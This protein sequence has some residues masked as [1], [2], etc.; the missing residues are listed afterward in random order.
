LIGNGAGG[1]VASEADGLQAQV[2]AGPSAWSAELAIDAALLGGWNHLAGLAFGHHA[3]NAGGDDYAW[4]YAATWT[5]PDTWAT[6][7]LGSQPVITS[8]DPFTATAGGP[9]FTLQVEGSGYVSGTQVLWNG[10]ALPTT[11][12]DEG[13]LAAAVGA[14]QLAAGGAVQVTAQAPGAGGAASNAATFL[15]ESAAPAISN[16]SPSSLPAGS[17]AQMLTISGS[18]FAAGAQVLW[19]GS[20]LPTEVLGT[21]QLRVQ[22]PAALLANG[23]T[24]GVAVRNPPPDERISP[25]IVF[26]VL[27]QNQLRQYRLYLPLTA[28]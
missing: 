20:P 18:N 28:R 23:Q 24:A 16:L 21:T 2:N 9:A 25:P 7:V 15:V 26:E 3:V 10:S 4:P 22:L 1:W 6:T 12:A 14:A 11:F 17:A 5:Q 8:L 19:D 13:H 27:P